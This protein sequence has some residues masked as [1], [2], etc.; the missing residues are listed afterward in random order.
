MI[1][2]VDRLPQTPR[3]VLGPDQRRQEAGDVA[4]RLVELLL[5]LPARLEGAEAPGEDLP[6]EEVLA[7][8]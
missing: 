8:R 6:S 1:S 7:T 3:P 4:P 5:E 2:D